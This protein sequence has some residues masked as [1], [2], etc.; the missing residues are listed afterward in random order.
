MVVRVSRLK[1]S[2]T[3]NEVEFLEANFGNP[4]FSESYCLATLEPEGD[5]LT[6]V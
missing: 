5:D 2:V 6:T 4:S 1:N 3:K